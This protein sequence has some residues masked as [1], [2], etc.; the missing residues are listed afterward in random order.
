M[1]NSKSTG[2]YLTFVIDDKTFAVPILT[3]QGVVGNPNIIQIADNTRLIVGIYH[4][5]NFDI[6][7]LD[8]RTILNKPNKIDPNKTCVVIVGV[9][10]RGLEK[11][12][13]FIVDSLLD[14]YHIQISDIEKLPICE[15]NGYIDGISYQQKKM[16]L[17]LNLEKIINGKNVI[18]FLNKF[19]CINKQNSNTVSDRSEKNGI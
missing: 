15:N 4:M 19:W 1:K 8:L 7:I 18:Y 5:N 17:H 14:I 13:G 11:L 2:N 3:L 6:P 9:S 12:V 10:F 16:I